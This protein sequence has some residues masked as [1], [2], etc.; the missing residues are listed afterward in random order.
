MKSHLDVIKCL[1]VNGPECVEV[2]HHYV[3]DI[4]KSIKFPKVVEVPY[5]VLPQSR[6]LTEGSYG[7]A[8]CWK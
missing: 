8:A 3:M 7:G 2:M 6:N 1:P 4:F 5:A